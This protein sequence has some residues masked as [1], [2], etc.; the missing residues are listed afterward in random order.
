MGTPGGGLV[1]PGLK[2]GEGRERGVLGDSQV[3]KSPCSSPWLE[4]RKAFRQEVRH[5]SLG[6]SL[7]HSPY[8]VYLDEQRQSMVLALYCRKTGR[9]REGRKRKRGWPWPCGERGERE[10]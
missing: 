2:G 8:T 3:G 6:E 7:S 1:S 9:K 10:R 4:P 5:G